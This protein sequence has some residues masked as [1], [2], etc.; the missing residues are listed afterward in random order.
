MRE[1]RFV[2]FDR[3]RIR[4]ISGCAASPNFT[5]QLASVARKISMPERARMDSCRYNGSASTCFAVATAARTDGDATLFGF[6][7]AVVGALCSDTATRANETGVRFRD[8]GGAPVFPR[9]GS[10]MSSSG[11]VRTSA[12]ARSRICCTSTIR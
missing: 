10:R 2:V 1:Q 4:L 9:V 3:V 6:S 7:C 12:P 5:I 8:V 11:W